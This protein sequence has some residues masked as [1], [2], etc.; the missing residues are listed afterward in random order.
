MPQVG[1]AV[2]LVLLEQTTTL[3]C[4]RIAALRAKCRDYT[5][6]FVLLVNPVLIIN[7]LRPGKPYALI[8][9]II[10]ITMRS[11]NNVNACVFFFMIML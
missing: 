5:R 6:S 10:A 9:P 2:E 3:S 4:N 8:I 7:A 1:V 11:S